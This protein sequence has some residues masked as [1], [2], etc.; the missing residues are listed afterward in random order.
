MALDRCTLEASRVQ[1]ALL[2]G[3]FT[4]VADFKFDR[5]LRNVVRARIL[6]IEMQLKFFGVDTSTGLRERRKLPL[7]HQIM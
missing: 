3:C 7:N 5:K 6:M 2:P 1:N 4:C